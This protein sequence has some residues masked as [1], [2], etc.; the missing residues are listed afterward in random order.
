M[1]VIKVVEI[2]DQSGVRFAVVVNKNDKL[3]GTV[4]DGDIRRGLL[5]GISLETSIDQV[6]NLLPTSLKES[7]KDQATKIMEQKNLLHIPI[8]NCDGVVTDISVL[9]QAL[10]ATPR[11]NPVVLMAGGLGK[12]LGE[13]TKNT[14]KPLLKV[15]KK[16]ILETILENFIDHGF[17]NFYISVNYKSEMIKE[18]FGNG[19]KWNISIKYID[20]EIPL[21]T[22]GSL[23]LIP[24]DNQRPIFVMN[25]DLLT[26]VNFQDLL[27]YHNEHNFLGTMCVREYDF[28]VPFGVVEIEETKIKKIVEKPIHKFFV[29]AGVYVIGREALKYIPKDQSFDMPKLFEKI[30]EDNKTTSVFPIREYWIDVGRADD[31]K[32]ANY[33]YDE[34]FT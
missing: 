14:P 27:E 22:A 7:E 6:M 34:V 33:E 10:T 29:N 3:L 26:T 18:Y 9:N 24:D 5:R 8:T 17:H 16:P 28:Q 32:R 25:G 30:I 21:G 20:E 23:K 11:D 2:I 4:T 1:S 19:S 15:G 12:R 31:F 13:M